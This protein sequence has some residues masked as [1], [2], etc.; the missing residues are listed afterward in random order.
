MVRTLVCRFGLLSLPSPI[1]SNDR[2]GSTNVFFAHGIE[3]LEIS[4]RFSKLV[5]PKNF[6]LRLSFMVF[7]V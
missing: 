5:G 6:I 4:V 1:C 2:L 7:R 3:G